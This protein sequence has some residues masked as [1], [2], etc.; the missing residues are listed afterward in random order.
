MR[1]S[2]PGVLSTAAT[3]ALR[4]LAALALL[5]GCV[6]GWADEV[7]TT[8]S[9]E[10][11]RLVAALRP[12][13]FFVQLGVAD[14]VTAAT[15]GVTWDLKPNWLSSAWSV[16]IEASL[17]RWQSRGGQPSDS[18][19]LMQ[20]AL[21]PVFRYRFDEARSPWFVEGGIG[22]TVTSSIYRSRETHFSTAFNFGDHLGVGYA[23]G[24][25]RNSEVV[26]RAEHFSN[27]GIK[28]PNPGK[29]FIELRF[30]HHLK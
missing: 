4:G 8:T 11:S 15:A 28:E 12:D 26:L 5:A 7:V 3:T 21:I 10:S 6:A 17:S 18:G 14:E 30:A 27:A 19:T 20:L 9:D 25:T 16:Y 1:V 23:F 29:N 22:P 24:Q 13:A 2:G